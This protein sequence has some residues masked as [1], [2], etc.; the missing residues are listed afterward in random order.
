MTLL[1][2]IRQFLQTVR[3]ELK[4]IASNP[5]TSSKVSMAAL[6][7]ALLFISVEVRCWTYIVLVA[8]ITLTLWCCFSFCKNIKFYLYYT[9][10]LVLSEVA[11][12]VQNGF[13]LPFWLA[14]VMLLLVG[15][16]LF[17]LGRHL[18]CFKAFEP[19]S[20]DVDFD[21]L[22]RERE[23][24]LERLTRYFEDFKVL[25]VNSVWGNGK[26][27]L[28]EMFKMRNEDSYYYISINVMTLRLDCVEKFLVSEISRILEQNKIY[29]AA[30]A[31][32]AAFFH[33]DLFQGFGRFF[34]ANSSYTESFKTLMADINKLDRPLFITFEDIDRTSDRTI[35][36]KVFAISEMLTRWTSRVRILF[37]YDKSMLGKIFEKEPECYIEK[38]IPYAIDLTPISFGR[39]LKVLLKNGHTKG[40]F[41]HIN[42]KD[43]YII[44][45]ESHIGSWLEMAGIKD[46]GSVVT[47]TPKWYSIRTV[48]LFIKEVETLMAD[49]AA[50]DKNVVVLLL[51]AK[52]FL[53]DEIFN[54]NLSEGIYDNAI[55]SFEGTS[56]KIQK[57]LAA[58][59]G[60]EDTERRRELYDKTYPR[61]SANLYYLLLMNKLGYKLL[62]VKENTKASDVSDQLDGIVNEELS[63][64]R[65]KDC[66]EKLDRLVRHIYARGRSDRTNLENAVIELEKV[67]DLED[68]KR[69]LA[70][71]EFL[72]KA[73]YQDFERVDNETI[74]ILG[75]PQFL[76]IFKGFLLYERNSA[77][78][79]K[80]LDLYFSCNAITEITAGLIQC[81]NYC[82]IEY[83][84][85][86]MHVIRRFNELK[87]IGNINNTKSY[88]RFLRRYVT[89]IISMTGIS[90]DYWG[91]LMENGSADTE[92]VAPFKS[93]VSDV[94]SK[95][96][97]LRND[98]ALDIIK[99]DCAEMLSFLDKN[100]KLVQSSPDQKE[101][102]GSI[103][104]HTEIHN[105]LQNIEEYLNKEKL[106]SCMLD[107]FLADNYRSGNLK[108][109]EAI[110]LRKR[111]GDNPTGS[112]G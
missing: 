86:F 82:G 17:V 18:Y 106:S 54:I 64:I 98:T 6:L 10:I 51:F 62:R 36:Q 27:Y 40:T 109:T 25:G 45:S 5:Y 70:F 103:S 30:S 108:A 112:K 12:Y 80:L 21:N 49:D 31:K 102:K 56:C 83:H 94:M 60:I 50:N 2:E 38:Y 20:E 1:R 26:T 65:E 111:F 67:L 15:G 84:D 101:H 9:Y 22:F 78:W 11:L 42:E 87:I 19:I 13:S 39:C 81:L 97:V 90:D 100:I 76:P 79:L 99:D 71:K 41:S 4:R 107:N 7:L 85:V 105:P 89:R 69:D 53:S 110:S 66:N 75:I 8:L 14:T 58:L 72:N 61:N 91:Y 48:E 73:F 55:F 3:N 29:S 95:L 92:I 68:D 24:D 43:F 63:G 37:Q 77:Y 93:H 52:H 104:I 46:I 35:A 88:A 34:T 96:K 16:L 44:T 33:G 59:K 47:L 32:L 28:Y 57:I 23:Q 74:F